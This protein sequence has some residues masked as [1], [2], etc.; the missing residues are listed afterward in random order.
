MGRVFQEALPACARGVWRAGGFSGERSFFD[1]AGPDLRF[2][3]HGGVARL[4]GGNSPLVTQKFPLWRPWLLFTL[5]TLASA[6]H[7]PDAAKGLLKTRESTQIMIFYLAANVVEDD[8]EALLLVK[9][10]LLATSVAAL[11]ALGVSLQTS[12]SLAAGRRVFSAR[13]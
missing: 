12:L 1:I 3:R 9:A 4:A 8:R 5:L 11:Y 7:S 6:F 13:I 10:L 2:H